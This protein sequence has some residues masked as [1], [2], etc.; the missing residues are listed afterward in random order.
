VDKIRAVPDTPVP[1][2]VEQ[3]VKEEDV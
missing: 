2:P 1:A 3:D